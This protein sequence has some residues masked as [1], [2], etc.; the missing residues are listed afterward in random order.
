MKKETFKQ[1]LFSAALLASV[2][3]VQAQDNPITFTRDMTFREN[4][5]WA[6]SMC[7]PKIGDFDNDGVN[8]LWL[9]GQRQ[10]YSWQTRTVFAKGLGERTFQADFEPIMETEL[11][12]TIVQKTDTIWKTDESGD[13]VLDGEGN[14]IVEEIIPVV[15]D[16][17]K[18]VNDTIVTKNEVYVGTQNGLPQ[19]AWSVGSQPIDFNADGLVDYLIL[20]PGKVGD[21]QGYILV[22]NL[23]NGKFEAVEDEVLSSIKFSENPKKGDYNRFNEDNAY[24]SVVTGDYDKD[25]YVDLLIT[26]NA[27]DGRFV[28]LLRN[29]NGERF[30]EMNVFEPLPF[31]VEN[32]HGL[33]EESGAG[34]DPETG[35]PIES[36]YFQD[37]P[38]MKAKPLSHG[39]VVFFDMDNDGWLDI[40]VSGY[41]DGTAMGDVG[42]EPDGDE[43]RFYRNQKDG[44]FKD[45]TDQ[46]IP[47]AQDVLTNLGL[48]T[49]GTLADVFTAWGSNN[50]VMMAT[51]YNQDGL[52][53]L[54]ISGKKRGDIHET[55][56]LINTPTEGSVFSFVEETVPMV[57]MTDAG[58]RG[59]FY[60]DFNGDDVPDLYHRGHSDALKPDGNKWD[61]CRVFEVSEGGSVGLYTSY[62]LGYWSNDIFGGFTWIWDDS[63]PVPGNFGDVD[64]DGKLDIMAGGYEGGTD[65]FIISYNETDYEPVYP[66]AP[67]EVTAEAAENG[68]VTVKWPASY[69]SNGNV[70]VHNVY[71]RNNETG[72]VRMLVPANTE[73]GKQLAYS[74]FGAY[75]VNYS[76]DEGLCFYVFEKL[77]AG[78]YTVGVQAVN[79]A[80]LA[81]GFTTTEVTVTDGYETSIQALEK[82][83]DVKVAIEGNV[84]TVNSSASAA[85]AIYNMQGAE[86]ATGM[87]NTPIILNGRG[88]FVVKTNHKAVKIVK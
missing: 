70:A 52:L 58:N 81:S 30:E 49:T 45:V 42:V 22:K 37:Q 13:F 62:D 14:K 38:T 73:T 60:A 16:E 65:N 63:D 29:V 76:M 3:E 57:G 79:Y 33:W 2:F 54:W 27:Y 23:G 51:D 64:N 53:D 87:T 67:A 25:G 19:T 12:S 86:V 88:V 55:F 15:D 68:Q 84:I 40:V 44:T 4:Y 47:V 11:D 32:R 82:Q 69:L 24:T 5:G 43:I 78:S 17:G 34:E 26:G 7:T 18:P 9:D 20:H 72:A 35:D 1:V 59:F 56:C 8:D 50:T 41:A 31:D 77:P 10:S 71:I 85:V 66:D 61:W 75:A 28:K 83:T 80:Y 74:M 48:D 46:L 36:V 6:N 21:L 39:S